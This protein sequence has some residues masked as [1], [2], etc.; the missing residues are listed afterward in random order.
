MFFSR[1][2]ADSERGDGRDG[3]LVSQYSCKET[4]CE[5]ELADTVHVCYMLPTFG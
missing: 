1:R 5:S 2:R 3:E 4:S